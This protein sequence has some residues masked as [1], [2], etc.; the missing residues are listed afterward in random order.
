MFVI[1]HINLIRSVFFFEENIKRNQRIF[2]D[3][4]H[5]KGLNLLYFLLK[6]IFYFDKISLS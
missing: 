6:R 2:L 5:F 3:S 1:E 4:F